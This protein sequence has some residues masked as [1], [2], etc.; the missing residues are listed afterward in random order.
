M[1]TTRKVLASIVALL[2]ACLVQAA[3]M[4]PVAR[5]TVITDIETEDIGGYVAWVAK[6][7]E[8]VKAKVGVDTFYHVYTTNFDGT[9]TSSVRLVS[10]AESVVALNKIA[11]AI[12][13]DPAFR[14]ITDRY[15]AI[16]KNGARVLN[17]GVRFDGSYKDAWVYTTLLKVTDEA[18]YLKALDGLRALFDAKDLKDAKINAYRVL[19]GR[20]NYT[21]RVSISVPTS[22]RLAAMMDF[23]ASDASMAAWLA[24]TAKYRTVVSNTTAHD[25]TK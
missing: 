25:V 4:K 3:D 19:A 13:G 21:H 22:D 11:T 5:V 10:S 23:L 1:K 24:D 16:R 12:N 15:R 20:T 8:F 2:A 14:E 6:A 18:G 9:K 7:N 17:Q